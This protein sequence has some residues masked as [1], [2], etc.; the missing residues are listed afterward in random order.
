L[1]LAIT[2]FWP[3]WAFGSAAGTAAWI[4]FLVVVF[5]LCKAS[6]AGRRAGRR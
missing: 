5:A 1:F 3:W 2:G 6:A 4:T